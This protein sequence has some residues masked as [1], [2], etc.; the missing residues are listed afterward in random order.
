MSSSTVRSSVAAHWLAQN[1]TPSPAAYA[2]HV[3][4]SSTHPRGARVS[5]GRAAGRSAEGAAPAGAGSAAVPAPN[6]YAPPASTLVGRHA[7]DSRL[8]G[9]QRAVI[10]T[11]ARAGS[12]P[13]APTPGPAAYDAAEADAGTSRHRVAPAFSMPR[14]PAGAAPG[15]GAG[16]SAPSSL[17]FAAV[18][19]GSYAPRDGALSNHPQAPRARMGVASRER[20][21]DA[22]GAGN[23]NVGPASYDVAGLD[24]STGARSVTRPRS[25][26]AVIGRAARGGGSGGGGGGGGA[27]AGAVGPAD[28]EPLSALRMTRPTSARAVFGRAARGD[29]GAGDLGSSGGAGGGGGGERA[30][31]RPTTPGPGAYG[32]AEADLAASSRHLAA[33]RTRIGSAAR[34][35]G[36]PREGPAPNAYVMDIAELRPCAP[37]AVMGRAD[38]GALAPR[39]AGGAG[40]ASY[41]PD[42]AALSRHAL[43]PRTRIGSAGR[44]AGAAAGAGAAG[45]ATP[46]PAAYETLPRRR[47]SG[48][49]IGA[50]GRAPGG[51]GAGPAPGS[52][53]VERATVVYP[54][55]ARTV[56]G[57]TPRFV[58]LH[59]APPPVGPA[60]YSS[61]PARAAT[62]PR[63][64]AFTMR[65]R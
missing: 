28:Y 45:G 56:F 26:R 7:E 42:A 46:G 8:R 52:Y 30:R 6:A 24:A 61:A 19:P 25:A 29:G 58:D 38:R 9:V 48:G 51:A 20:R 13:R 64:P 21:P 62:L 5:I 15:T 53:Y 22:G 27:A 39:P 10:G 55:H 2:P 16:S 33:P 35:R 41:A 34:D 11:A 18:G 47:V 59:E 50:A 65:A 17:A 4:A 12:A 44:F 3:E 63:S 40:P 43:A 57:H 60:D 54:E 14:G 23:A 32:A 31:S 49:F 1:A 37:R 36:A